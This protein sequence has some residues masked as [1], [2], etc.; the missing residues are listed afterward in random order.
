VTLPSEALPR[1]CECESIKL[2][3]YEVTEKRWHQPNLSPE[4]VHEAE[5]FWVSGEIDADMYGVEHG[6]PLSGNLVGASFVTNI[7]GAVLRSPERVLEP[8]APP[9]TLADDEQRPIRQSQVSSVLVEDKEREKFAE[10][11][12]RDLRIHRW[13]VVS[14]K[15]DGD[16]VLVR[17]RGKAYGRIVMPDRM[18]LDPNKTLLTTDG[19]SYSSDEPN[20]CLSCSLLIRV[21]LSLLIWWLCG[22]P[23]A[24]LSFVVTWVTCLQEDAGYNFRVYRE[25]ARFLPWALLLLSL[26]GLGWYLWQMFSGNCQSAPWW[27]LLLPALALLVSPWVAECRMRIWLLLLF[28]VSLWAWCA[29]T[30]GACHIFSSTS[31]TPSS[32]MVPPVVVAPNSS[33]AISSNPVPVTPT[34]VSTAP[35]GEVTTGNPISTPN[36]FSSIVESINQLLGEVITGVSAVSAAVGSASGDAIPPGSRISLDQA[37]NQPE[38]FASCQHAVYMPSTV[39]FEYNESAIREQVKPSMQ[40]IVQLLQRYPNETFEITGHADRTGERT[41]GGVAHNLQLSQSRANSMGEWLSSESGIPMQR[42]AMQGLGTR[43]P[44]TVDATMEQ[45]NRRVE[46]KLRCHGN[47]KRGGR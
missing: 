7:T 10:C 46:L 15:V 5:S 11:A 23:L 31:N 44:I 19:S 41:D 18:K 39:L 45:Y 16:G 22:A 2:E 3:W 37:L 24:V 26:S 8:F 25:R 42:F 28:Q 35:P 43:I 12:L 40:R 9:L 4:I 1:V 38:L 33:P 47:S 6:A 30:G 13:E 17:V 32:V 21:L 14:S 29:A 36:S 20:S 34:V 27:S